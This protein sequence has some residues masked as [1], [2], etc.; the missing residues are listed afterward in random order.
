LWN[1]FR[2]HVFLVAMLR[3]CSDSLSLT[4]CYFITQ[5]ILYIYASEVSV[6]KGVYLLVIFIL[7]NILAQP[8]I[9]SSYFF[10]GF[11][12]AINMRKAIVLA[13][14]NKVS[15]LSLKS[16]AETNSGKL[17]TLISSDLFTIERMMQ[18][19]PLL[20][21]A[22]LCNIVAYIIIGFTAGWAYTG[23][24]FVMTVVLVSCQYL[25]AIRF[26]EL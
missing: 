1:V 7:L 24:I 26:K 11:Y 23:I 25:V 21:S 10:Q 22:P 5:L 16:L 17:I 4:S 8:L 20:I 3:T 15:K 19:A 6:G 18:F 13:M 9:Q 14:Y 12:Y 2:W